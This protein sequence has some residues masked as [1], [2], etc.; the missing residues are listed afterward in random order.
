MFD[1][2]VLGGTGLISTAVTRQLAARGARVTVFNR[3]LRAGAL[4][5]GVRQ[6]TGDRAD[7]EAF[8]GAFARERFDVVIDMICYTPEH[9]EDTA[10]AFR[11]RCAQVI[12][13][14]S[15]LTYGPGLPPS[16]LVDEA[17]PQEPRSEYG[18]D[19]VACERLLQRAADG[20]AFALT[21]LRAAHTYG[22]GGPMDDPLGTDGVAWDRVARGLPLLL[23][24]DGLGLWQSTHRDDCARLFAH[25]AMN[26]RTFGEAYNATR[27]EVITWRD[28]HREVARAL[29]TRAAVICAPTRWLLAQ[30]GERFGF[31]A[32]VAGF[33]H[34]YSSAKARAHVPEFRPAIGLEA[35][36]RETFADQ[37]ARGAWPDAR[38]DVAY[39]ALVQRALAIGLE[40]EEA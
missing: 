1:A 34:A 16:A 33:H 18:R 22:P 24:G 15:A 26:E 39:E 31:L 38:A 23:P 4:P 25:A 27:D 7:R 12:L 36:A 11:G 9:A 21:V 14:S 20:G 19:K 37:R 2:L 29:D 5:D 8:V 32:E 30:G 10:R 6:I 35:G 3:G 40:V 17:R 28:Y 13:C